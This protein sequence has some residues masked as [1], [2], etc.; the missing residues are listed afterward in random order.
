MLSRMTSYIWRMLYLMAGITS[1]TVLTTPLLFYI[2]FVDKSWA[3]VTCVAHTVNLAG[4]LY[5]IIVSIRYFTLLRKSTPLH[6]RIKKTVS[7]RNNMEWIQYVT[8]NE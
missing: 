6:N 3:I 5:G 2:R 7:Y 8:D 4:A 1:T